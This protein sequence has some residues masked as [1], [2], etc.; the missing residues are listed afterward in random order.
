MIVEE[1]GNLLNIGVRGK[2]KRNYTFKMKSEKGFSLLEVLISIVL[3]AVVGTAFLNALVGSSKAMFTAD[4]M[5]TAKNLAETQMEYVKQQ[6]FAGS[7]SSD[8]V[9]AEYGGYSVVITAQPLRDNNIQKVS[10][11]VKF[12]NTDVFTLEDYKVKR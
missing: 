10:I 11:L 8:A 5:A 1:Y 12:N 6:Q 9:P 3:L 4:K 2:M 7:Y